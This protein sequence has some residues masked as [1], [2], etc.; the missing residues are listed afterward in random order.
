MF[1]EDVTQHILVWFYHMTWAI[2]ALIPGPVMALWARSRLKAALR[3]GSAPM[4]IAGI[5][6]ERMVV[7]ILQ[8]AH[9]EGVTVV[10]APGPLATFYDW[11]QRQ[12]R[13]AAKVFEGQSVALVAVAAH[14]AGHVLQPRFLCAL[15][16][17]MTF[18]VRLAAIAAILMLVSGVAFEFAYMTLAAALIY[19]GS[20]GVALVMALL[21]VDANRR[22]RRVMVG[23]DLGGVESS[24]TFGEAL[25]AACFSQVAE[26]LPGLGHVLTHS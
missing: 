3:Q 16:T 2:I 9:I 26:M 22:V 25:D 6:G 10:L 5:T 21:G 23:V 20:V 12:L 11:Q 17:L 15:R 8:D 14:E 1:W 7:R 4:P 18:A 24:P 19:S 13:L